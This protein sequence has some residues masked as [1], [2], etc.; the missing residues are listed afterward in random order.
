MRSDKTLIVLILVLFISFIIFAVALFESSDHSSS[1]SGSR[2]YFRENLSEQQKALVLGIAMN[3]TI[4]SSE[5]EG[6]SAAITRGTMGEL[7]GQYR[8]E[9]ISVARYDDADV[10]VSGILP[11]V[12]FIAGNMSQEGPTLEAFVDPDAGR[13][14]YIRET[15]RPVNGNPYNIHL[16]NVSIV[17]TGYKFNDNLTEEEQTRALAIALANESVQGYLRGANYTLNGVGMAE[18]GNLNGYSTADYVYPSVTFY[19]PPAR[20]IDAY[21]DIK[22]DRVIGVIEFP[23][24]P[25]L[26]PPPEGG[27]AS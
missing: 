11:A 14:A 26:L 16:I 15:W 13:V 4:L 17:N 22:N 18:F 7:I 20:M 5:L 12:T 3:D 6:T 10:H 8:V 27:P 24:T 19:V 1:E 9:G 25:P 2:F 23:V 21:V